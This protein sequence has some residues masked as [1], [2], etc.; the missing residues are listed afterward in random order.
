[1]SSI[2]FVDDDPRVLDGLRNALRKWRRDWDMTFALGPTSAFEELE[3]RPYDVIVTDMRMPTM[4]GAAF[5][6]QARR[7]HGD[8]V[9]VVLSG[10][11]ESEAAMRAVPVAHQFLMKPCPPERLIDV[12]K[13]ALALEQLVSDEALRRTVASIEQLPSVPRIYGDLTAA[14]ANVN[15]DARTVASVIEQDPAMGA[16]VLQLVN[17]AFF[18]TPVATSSVAQAVMRLGFDCVRDLALTLEVFRPGTMRGVGPSVLERLQRHAMLTGTLVRAV[19]AESDDKTVEQA[20]LAA[21]LHDVGHLVFMSAKGRQYAAMERGAADEVALV[22][23]E[24]EA[25]Q[26][27][28]AELGAYLLGLWGLPYTVV[29]GVAHHHDPERAPESAELPWMV[30]VAS[31]AA[32]LVE[33]DRRLTSER[34]REGFRA[35][36]EANPER[37]ALV[38][39]A[40][41]GARAYL[42][43]QGGK[44]HDE[45]EPT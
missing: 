2:L 22:V 28:H 10:F 12:I 34:F 25:H 4:D 26:I 40:W 1:M 21:M 35:F 23:A 41:D 9:R 18:A 42:A 17:S 38:S 45:L 5:L 15:A 7:R 13:R 33:G 3:R 31:R 11:A 43:R 20:T 8:T 19:A 32:E 27:S 14:L 44:Q 36:V 37:A 24:R 30:H 16:K 39:L 6:E 29:E